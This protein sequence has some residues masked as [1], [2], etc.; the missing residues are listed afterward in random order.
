MWWDGLSNFQQIIFIIAG[1]S[2]VILFIFLILLL[3]GL[4]DESFDGADVDD[5]DFDPFNDEPLGAFSGLKILSLRGTLA[6]LSIGGWVAFILEPELGIAWSLIIG[7]FSGFIASLLLAVAF[8][9]SLRLE[10]S[11]NIDYKNAIGKTAKV[12][13]RV[14]KEKSGI[15]KVNLVL[16][17]RLV[18]I[19]A[20][21]DELE[22]LKVNEMVIIIGLEDE[23]TLLVRNRKGEDV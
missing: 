15:G 12:Y 21:T 14:P 5:L 16:Q 17:E 3:L 7:I 20:I 18:E 10:S 9:M 8:K 2:T 23:R 19:D 4:G 22:D 13:L 11:G 6:F 1:S